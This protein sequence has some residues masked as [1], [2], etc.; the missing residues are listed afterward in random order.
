MKNAIKNMRAT[1]A[2]AAALMTTVP[3]F[4]A[5]G[6]NEK[7]VEREHH[8]ITLHGR[9]ANVYNNEQGKKVAEFVV[10]GG[11]TLKA[12]EGEEQAVMIQ[13]PTLGEHTETVNLNDQHGLKESFSTL[14]ETDNKRK[15]KKAIFNIHY[16]I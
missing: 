1:L 11:Y 4:A 15:Q 5:N 7:S 10:N 14:F 3:A 16:N 2:L 9:R 8:T 6:E 13:N 12:V